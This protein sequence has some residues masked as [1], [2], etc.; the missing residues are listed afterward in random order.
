MVWS[1]AFCRRFVSHCGCLKW[2]LYPILEAIINHTWSNA[3]SSRRNASC[4]ACFMFA[5]AI[6]AFQCV[7]KCLYSLLHSL[8]SDLDKNTK[9]LKARKQVNC[10]RHIW[11]NV[12]VLIARFYIYLIHTPICL[13]PTVKLLILFYCLVCKLLF[14]WRMCIYHS[15]SSANK[16]Q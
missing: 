1:W 13:V 8:F 10:E 3:E 7:Y 16:A 2:T 6:L 12:Y 9:K 15:V 4:N 14:H 5:L 11:I